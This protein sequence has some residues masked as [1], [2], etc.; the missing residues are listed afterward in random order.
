[1]APK[2]HPNKKRISEKE[3]NDLAFLEAHKVVYD[4]PSRKVLPASI[5]SLLI[6]LCPLFVF[7]FIFEVSF[8]RYFYLH[9]PLVIGTTVFLFMAHPL[10]SETIYYRLMA[11]RRFL[12]TNSS[13]WH[14]TKKKSAKSVAENQRAEQQIITNDESVSIAVIYNNLLFLVMFLVLSC[15]VLR[16]FHHII[17]LV[18]SNSVSAAAVLFSARYNKALSMK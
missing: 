16:Q 7:V 3:R 4:F 10:I 18:V 14:K 9:A 5:S 11:R 8:S 13:F 17:N 12:V 6:A 15:F 1:M 2:G